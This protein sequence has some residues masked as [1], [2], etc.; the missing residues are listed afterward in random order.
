MTPLKTRSQPVPAPSQS[1]FAAVRLRLPADWRPAGPSGTSLRTDE[2][3]FA[4]L[5]RARAIIT[6]PSRELRRCGTEAP[7]RLKPAPVGSGCEVVVARALGNPWQKS[8]SL[9]RT[10]AGSESV[11]DR[12]LNPFQ[13]SGVLAR[14][15]SGGGAN[16]T[17]A[18]R[19]GNGTQSSWFF[20][21]VQPPA[22]VQV[23]CARPHA[24]PRTNTSMRPVELL[25]LAVP[26]T[27]AEKSA[28]SSSGTI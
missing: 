11:A 14:R 5:P 3:R 28:C 22:S 9:G 13:R 16:P 6:A 15:R 17:G 4:N 1:R 8:R 2:A 27:R 25:G 10:A 23:I 18:P 7:R 24:W 19:R 12:A 21:L 26:D 20:Q